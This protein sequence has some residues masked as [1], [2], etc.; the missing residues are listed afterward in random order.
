MWIFRSIE[1]VTFKVISLEKTELFVNILFN[2]HLQ[3]ASE[4]KQGHLLNLS[5]SVSRGKE[6]N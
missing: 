3:Y 1:V 2:K 4:I 5:I 6:I